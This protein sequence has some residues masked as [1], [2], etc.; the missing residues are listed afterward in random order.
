MN[1]TPEKP[2]PKAGGA[3]IAIFTLLG[4]VGGVIF[5]QPSIGLL[6]GFGFGCALA[7]VVWLRDRSA[8]S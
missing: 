4:A 8:S 3:L 5:G 2:G 7:I 1:N 6:A